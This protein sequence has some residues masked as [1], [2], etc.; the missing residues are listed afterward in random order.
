MSSEGVG[1]R[2]AAGRLRLLFGVRASLRLE[3]SNPS[4]AVAEVRLPA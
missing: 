3:L 1:L 2:N 4:L